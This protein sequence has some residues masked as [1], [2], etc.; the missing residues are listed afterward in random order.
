MRITLS[1]LYL[2]LVLTGLG[3][4]PL[5]AAPVDDGWRNPPDQARLRAYWWWLN[6]N[7][8]R[9]SITHDLEAMREKGFGGVL[10]CDANGADHD[11][12]APVPHGPTFAS[13][14]WRELYLHALREADRLHLEVTLNILSGWNLGGPVV[15]TADAVQ[16][17]TWTETNVAG[18]GPVTITLL[19]PK[20]RDNYYQDIAVVAYRVDPNHHPV[21]LV[22]WQQKALQQSLLP[23]STP[24]STPLFAEADSTP[25]DADTAASAVVNLTAQMDAQGQLTWNAP[26][27]QWRVFRFGHTVGEHGYVST[28]SDGWGGHALDVYS[29]DAFQRYWNRIVEPLVADA[30]PLAGKSL[31]YLYTDSWEIELANWTPNLPAEFQQRNGYDLLP[32]LPVLA[33]HIVNSREQSDRFLFDYRKTLGD[34]A[35][36]HHYRLFRAGA[37]RHGLGIHCESGGPHAVPI[38]AQRCLGWDN[39]PMSEFWA[40]SWEHRIGDANRFFMKQPASAAHTYGHPFV[41]GEGFTDIGL[42]WQESLWSNLK[43]TFDFA[44]CEGLNR[45]VWHAYVCSPDETG[46]PGQQY[47][48]GTHLNPKVTWWPESQAFFSYINRCQWMMQQ[49]HFVAD[50]LYYYGDHVPNFSQ[51]KSSDP[52]HLG[53]GYDYDVITEEAL[54]ERASVQSGRI[55]LPGGMS[56]RLLILPNRDQISLPVLQKVRALV[57]AGATVLG[58]QPVRG[59]T[60]RNYPAV[61]AQIAQL[62]EEIWGGHLHD[63]RVISNHTA[64][65][66]LLGDGVLP[67][68]EFQA[69]SRLRANFDFIHRQDGNTDIYFLSSRTNEPTDALVTLRVAGRQ[70]ELWDAVTGE[71]RAVAFRTEADNRTT[72]PLH[73]NPCGSWLLVFRP[74]AERPSLSAPLNLEPSAPVATVNGPWTAHF[75]PH[76]GGPTNTTF[77]SLT[78]WTTRPEPG[79][80]YYSGAATYEQTLTLTPEQLAD[81]QRL[82][83][84]LGDVREL[85]QVTVNGHDCGITWC[86]PFRVDVTHALQVGP[87]QLAV[88]VVNFWP[89]RIIGDASLPPAQRLTRTN[90]RALKANTPLMPSGLLGPVTLVAAP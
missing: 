14:A 62:G 32:W 7:V 19:Q 90:I 35:I 39:E 48:A 2:G 61:D 44:I 20:A 22:N 64:R 66:V 77:D 23:F 11:R 65:E 53:A 69:P 42:N 72:I 8:T 30:G 10:L 15:S 36:D 49:G 18:G 63:G 54:I 57:A 75:D 25:D 5:A 89:N 60:L 85:A 67:D 41:L 46:I 71:R 58:P 26:P 51:L 16:Q 31:K 50:A 55:V 28:S 56:Y 70:P 24:D 3:L 47:F 86:P 21:H 27:G 43:P 37:E 84:D 40:W 34:L 29:A 80:R 81:G 59:E 13:P 68:C 17:Y 76:W 82:W 38:D 52:C 1:C 9:A 83:L 6:G 45:L 87:N 12:N 74:D 33:G 78:S 4:A 79:I 73:F 88:K